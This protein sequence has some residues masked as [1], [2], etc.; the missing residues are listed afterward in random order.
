MWGFCQAHLGDGR[1]RWRWRLAI[2]LLSANYLTEANQVA[3][4]DIQITIADSAFPT[5]TTRNN[6]QYRRITYNVNLE[7]PDTGFTLD[8][9]NY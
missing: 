9:D 7:T 1:Y 2:M 5:I 3:N 8:P 4:P 6:I